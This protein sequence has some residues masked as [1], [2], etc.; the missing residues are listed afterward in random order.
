MIKAVQNLLF[1]LQYLQLGHKFPKQV[2]VA[3]R[4]E[5]RLFKDKLEDTPLLGK[6]VTEPEWGEISRYFQNNQKQSLN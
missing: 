3:E 4:N 1:S 2:K 5:E 6:A